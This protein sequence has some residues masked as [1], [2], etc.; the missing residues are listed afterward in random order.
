METDTAS[1]PPS[2]SLTLDPFGPIAPRPRRLE[3]RLRP[4][5]PLGIDP[6]DPIPFR[7]DEHSA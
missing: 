5:D 1:P 6:L 3:D 4:A 7:P 2:A